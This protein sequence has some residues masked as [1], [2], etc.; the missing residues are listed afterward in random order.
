MPKMKSKS[1]ARKR[2]KLMGSGRIK[3]KKAFRRHLLNSKSAKRGRHLRK[4][5]MVDKSNLAQVKRM[6]LA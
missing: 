1:G 4:G 2:L 6:L 5:A 3:R